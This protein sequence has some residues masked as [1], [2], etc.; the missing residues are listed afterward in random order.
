[1]KR[2][3]IILLIVQTI[4]VSSC[5]KTLDS[6]GVSANKVTTY[7]AITLTKGSFVTIPKGQPFVDPGFTALIGTQDVK[8][9]VKIEGTVDG[10]KAGLYVLHYSAVNDDGFS[11][12]ATR[13]VIIYDPAAP[14]TD[15]TGAYSSSVKRISPARSFSNLSVTINKLA[16]GF[17]YVSDFLGGFYD[18]GSN[19][20]YGPTYAMTGYMQLNADNTITLVSSYISG[21]GDSLNKLTNGIFNPTTKTVSWDAFYSASN[22]DFVVTLSLIQ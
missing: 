16:P 17:F 12:S 7:V 8:N 6:E 1:M 22:Y 2:L 14:P 13:T 5:K 4:V 9:K 21:W 11:S 3:L 20:K 15:L 18:Q 19:Y 10:L